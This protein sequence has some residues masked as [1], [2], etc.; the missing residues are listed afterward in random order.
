MAHLQGIARGNWRRGNPGDGIRPHCKCLRLGGERHT[1][2]A[3]RI[4]KS[5]DQ[6]NAGLLDQCNVG[7]AV[8]AQ[9]E[10]SWKFAR[11]CP[12]PFTSISRNCVHGGGS[13]GWILDEHP[14]LSGLFQHGYVFL[15]VA[16]E[17]CHLRKPERPRNAMLATRRIDRGL[18]VRCAAGFA[19]LGV[20][21]RLD[22]TVVGGSTRVAGN[23]C[24]CIARWN[25]PGGIGRGWPGT[26]MASTSQQ[27]PQSDGTDGKAASA[28][29]EG[30]SPDSQPTD[31]SRRKVRERTGRN[32]HAGQPRL[33][34]RPS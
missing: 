29:V 20:D 13:G 11:Y 6:A 17:I 32:Q 12:L 8:P 30:F 26:R 28:C 22:A 18:P 16:V 31:E 24:R 5:A 10:H 1:L 19:R 21:R 25:G 23:P 2:L 34:R 9:R 7:K 15:L 14:A 4:R 27:C 3:D 33:I